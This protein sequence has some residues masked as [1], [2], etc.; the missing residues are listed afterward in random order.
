MMVLILISGMAMG[1]GMKVKRAT[2]QRRAV[3]ALRARWGVVL[4]DYQFSDGAVIP[5]GKPW[6]PAWIRR[7]VGDDFF[8]SP[9]YAARIFA[10]WLTW[11][12]DD[13]ELS[14]LKHFSRL[15][16]L[17]LSCSDKVT[18]DGLKHLEGLTGLRSL[19]LHGEGLTSPRLA[20][21]SRLTGLKELDL[22]GSGLTDE[23][24]VFLRPL[25]H[26]QS[27]NLAGTDVTDEGI[28]SLHFLSEL[29]E[30]DLSST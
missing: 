12:V 15:E 14:S 16:G 18:D 23:G 25:I 8:C 2:D 6:A 5:N 22:S 29:R 4:Y 17:E 1:I 30:L 7:V 19:A 3:A 21:L 13:E 27:L 10:P 20:H 26:L 28:K 9:T 11:P 24:I